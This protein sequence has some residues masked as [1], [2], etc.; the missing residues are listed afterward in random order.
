MARDPLAPA[1]CKDCGTDTT[2]CTNRAGCRHAGR[3]E[4]YMVLP[5][6]WA[7]VG[8]TVHGGFLCIGCLEKRL[9]RQLRA[10]DFTVA[11]INMVGH[12]WSSARLEAALTRK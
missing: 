8:M 2:P 4:W 10:A 9:G 1:P 6:I 11:P 3:W 5:A 7:A 12:P